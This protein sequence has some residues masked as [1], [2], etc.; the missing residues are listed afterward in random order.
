MKSYFHM[1]GWALETRFAKEAKDNSKM[2]YYGLLV[3]L[4]RY[5]N[6]PNDDVDKLI[7]CAAS[8]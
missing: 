8:S 3:T 1:K 7:C 4:D 2:T 5:L 6:P